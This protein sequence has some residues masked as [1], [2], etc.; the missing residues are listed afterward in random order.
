MVASP[1]APT[2]TAPSIPVTLVNVPPQSVVYLDD[3]QEA[4]TSL[5]N[6]GKH[7]YDGRTPINWLGKKPAHSLFTH[8]AIT[9]RYMSRILGEKYDKF[10]TTIGVINKPASGLIF[11]VYG[12]DKL[13]WQS[14][15]QR[16]AQIGTDVDLSV[17]SVRALSLR[18]SA[19]A[20]FCTPTPCGST[21][22]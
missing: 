5:K 14:P 22:G 6:L 19:L 15:P 4:T 20:H 9:A 10:Q 11:R 7:G 16:Q 17:R 2:S 21:R 18:C 13:L 12:D 3:L 8:P 1:V